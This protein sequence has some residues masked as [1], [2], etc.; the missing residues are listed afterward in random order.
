MITGILREGIKSHFKKNHSNT[1]GDLWQDF[2][3]FCQ[4][5]KPFGSDEYHFCRK[6]SATARVLVGDRWVL[7]PLV[8]TTSLDGRTFADYYL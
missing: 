2:N 5:P 8:S 4:M 6:F 3:H 7:Q 1:L